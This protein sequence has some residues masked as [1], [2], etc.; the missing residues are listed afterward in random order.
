MDFQEKLSKYAEVAI[1]AALN[2]QPGQKLYIASPLY[3]S[4]FVR[5]V[6]RYAYRQ[7]ASFVDVMYRDSDLPRLRFE[8]APPDTFDIIPTHIVDTVYEYT[9]NG[10]ARL[11]II[12][13]DPDA[14]NGINPE[15]LATY[16]RALGTYASKIRDLGNA[17]NWCG[18]AIPSVE[19]AEKVFPELKGQQAVA[20][21]WDAI[22]AICRI[23]AADP[24]AAWEAHMANLSARRDWMNDQRFSAFHYTGPGTDL[25]VGLAD[26][27]EWFT[28]KWTAG[29]GVEFIANV[30]TEEIF[31]APHRERI[32]GT[33]AA[34]MP[35]SYSSTLIDQFS[36]T[37]KDGKVVDFRAAQ[38]EEVL[39]NLLE[40][41]DGSSSLGEVALVPHSSP[42]SQSGLI[43]YNT[44]FDENASC[45][46]A[47]GNAYSW[48]ISNGD[49]MSEEE[50]MN[51]GGN[52]SVVHVDFMIG[53][54]E[55]DIDG[56]RADG[57]AEPIMRNGEW[58]FEV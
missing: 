28:A 56:V 9:K 11:A 30:P 46:I 20:K 6:A 33:V 31:T 44:L 51:A 43:F 53:S 2:V 17:N 37:F 19:W 21:L 32:N 58:A 52:K 10:D 18:M 23:N 35:L 16:N 54:G 7:G 47:L 38:G 22:F 14:L 49:D 41:D 3:A 8:E 15:Y 25:K 12:G 42:I 57:S 1:K 13:E 34:T 24:I 55:I 27:H 26:G 36:L 45:H 48:T 4:D 29:N 5:E 40:T 50:F 39:R